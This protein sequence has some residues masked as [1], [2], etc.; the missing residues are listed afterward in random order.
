MRGLQCQYT[1]SILSFEYQR[2]NL[3][4]LNKSVIFRFGEIDNL[5]HLDAQHVQQEFRQSALA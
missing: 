3:A 2:N 1:N 5:V 4:F